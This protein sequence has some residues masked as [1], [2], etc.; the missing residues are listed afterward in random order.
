MKLPKYLNCDTQP[1][2]TILVRLPVAVAEFIQAYAEENDIPL[3]SALTMAL[4]HFKTDI[5]RY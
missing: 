4:L 1:T 5:E 2:S 3:D